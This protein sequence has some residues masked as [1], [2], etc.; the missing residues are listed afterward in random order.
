M[1]LSA[2]V[3]AV[4]KIFKVRKMSYL[5]VQIKIWVLEK[6]NSNISK[7]SIEQPEI[8]LLFS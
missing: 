2:D 3:L 7:H 6:L 5:V 8:F 1:S 4:K